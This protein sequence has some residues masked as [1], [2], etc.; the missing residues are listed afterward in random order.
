MY[1]LAKEGA[2][3]DRQDQEKTEKKAFEEEE[4]EK[5]DDRTSK[6]QSI[7]K[8][9]ESYGIEMEESDDE[10]LRKPAE[11][12]KAKKD[13]IK[14]FYPGNVTDNVSGTDDWANGYT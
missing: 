9:R 5:H 8:L 11:P 6:L 3:K 12:S 4:D 2:I 1:N 7:M 13:I 14:Q 10:D